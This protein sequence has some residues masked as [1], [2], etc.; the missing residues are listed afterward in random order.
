MPRKADAVVI[1]RM[2]C[3]APGC[4]DT[5]AV[6]QARDGFFYTRCPKCGATQ[7]R[8][9]DF[10]VAVW[11]RLEPVPGATNPKTGLPVVIQ[12]PR[13]VPDSAGDM[14]C[15]V[16]GKAPPVVVA[17]AGGAPT[18]VDP[19]PAEKPTAVPT[20]VPATDDSESV[21]VPTQPV[22][23]QA[24]PTEPEPKGTGTR[25]AGGW[26]FGKFMLGI[27]SVAL[28]VGGGVALA[29]SGNNSGS[30]S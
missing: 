22:E 15:A 13:N 17:E 11:Q 21:R 16:A 2:V 24:A 29:Q 14:G 30:G 28:V 27:L 25:K 10:Q 1:G 20:P 3:A 7:N 23:K 12:R 8:H 19:V 26:T 4:G 5:A 9:A 6:L 18:A